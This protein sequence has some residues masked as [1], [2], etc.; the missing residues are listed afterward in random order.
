[1]VEALKWAGSF[2]L[3]IAGVSTVIAVW[4]FLTI[5]GSLAT[6]AGS[7]IITITMVAVVI[8]EGF[9]HLFGKN[10]EGE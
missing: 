3:A 4:L 7:A 10:K 2:L 5:L 6:L 1:M 8:K 9:E